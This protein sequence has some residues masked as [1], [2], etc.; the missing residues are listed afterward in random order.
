MIVATHHIDDAGRLADQIV[1]LHDHCVY[2]TSDINST[3]RGRPGRVFLRNYEW[4]S[5]R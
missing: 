1:L 2:D 4:G 3:G 5:G